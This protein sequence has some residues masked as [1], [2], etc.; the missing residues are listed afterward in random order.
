MTDQ[1]TQLMINIDT[2]PDTDTEELAELTQ[3]L[4]GE[5]RELDV[6]SVD[7]VRA[8]QPHE[9]AKAGDPVTWGQLLVTLLASGGVV[10]TL[11][12]VL[13]SWLTRHENSSVTIEIDGDALEVTGI[14]SEQQQRLIN[15]WLS[16]HGES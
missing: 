7:L 14:P 16:R 1:T 10:V 11:V 12:N 9:R 4:R 5:L 2:D 3:Q 15:I 13:Q 6:E 8:G